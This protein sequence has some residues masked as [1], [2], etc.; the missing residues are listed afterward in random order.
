MN[1]STQNGF[2]IACLISILTSALHP[3]PKDVSFR[4]YTA[5]DGLVG[6]HIS[7]LLQD[8]QG[9]LWVGTANG[10]YR[11]DG[12]AFKA[13]KRDPSD[14]TSL[15]DNFIRALYEDSSAGGMLWVG[16]SNGL[17]ALDHRTEKLVHYRNEQKG[18]DASAVNF[19]RTL[20][21]DAQSSIWV[22]T[23]GGGLFKFDKSTRQFARFE[24]TLKNAKKPISPEVSAIMAGSDESIWIGTYKH[25][26]LRYDPASGI[27][28]QLVHDPQDPQSVEANTILTLYKDRN[29]TIW[30]GTHKGGLA[31]I[32][33]GKLRRE[34]IRV[35]QPDLPTFNKINSIAE[36]AD[37]V[38][39]LGTSGAG[40]I[41]YDPQ[42]GGYEI[43][44]SDP[45][46]PQKLSD[47]W[48]LCQYVD[49]A[50]NLWIGTSHGL[51]K[52]QS[53]KKKITHIKNIQDEPLSLVHNCVNAIWEDRTGKLWIGTDGGLSV[54]D[55]ESNFIA[56]Y[57]N[58]PNDARSLS[59]NFIQAIG[60]DKNGDIWIGTFGGGLNKFNRQ[61]QTF[62]RFRKDSSGA[63]HLSQNFVTSIYEDRR[64]DLWIGTLG[65]LNKFD[66]SRNGFIRYLSDTKNPKA[67]NHNGITCMF[68]DHAS[69][70][71][72]GTY[73]GGLNLMNRDSDEFIH[74][75]NDRSNPNSLS[76]DIVNCLY[77][78]KNGLLWIGTNSGLDR[79]DPATEQFSHYWE[80]DGLPNNV[81]LGILGDDG[82]NLWISTFNGLSKFDDGLPAGKKFLNFDSRKD[83]L[84]ANEFNTGAFHRNKRGELFFGGPNGLNRFYPQ[85]LKAKLL[86][87][88]IVIT[89]LNKFNKPLAL[90]TSIAAT[91]ELKFSHDDIFFSFDFAVLDFTLPER[92][93][94]AYRM[95][96]FNSDW[97]YCGNQHQATFT[98]LDAGA[99][100]FKVK[101][102]NSDGVW[103]EEGASLRI[104]IAPP[105][106][107]TWWF[108]FLVAMAFIGVL[109]SIYQYRV[110][111][112]LA[113][114]RLR[115]RIASDLH[116]DI[117]ATL[118]RISL[119]SELIQNG[120]DP[121]EVKSSLQK[122]GAMSRDLVTTMSDIVW[123]IDAR[124][125]T[126]GDLI[127][128]M[129][130]FASSVLSV[131]PVNVSFEVSGLDEHKRLP[132]PLRQNIYLI[133]KEA[134]NNIAKHAKAT[135]AEIYLK[136]SEGRF[137]MM[138]RDDG[139][140]F[141][142]NELDP[143]SAPLHQKAKADSAPHL[144]FTEAER[145]RG[146][147]TGHG[148]RNMKMR[149]ER[150][151]GN[152]EFKMDNGVSITL[153]GRAI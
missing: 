68:E 28:H 11:F 10:L 46:H 73:G 100:V 113:V 109:A 133:F 119:H 104:T 58:D 34:A 122:I 33:N 56:N 151:G 87:P 75:K 118:T 96:G 30:V 3:Q 13:F 41:A 142:E 146:K 112:L 25:G 124:N 80:K 65:G 71:W 144:E 116:D 51:N 48:I 5:E 82:G 88:A 81:V 67:L 103:N 115:V 98:N 66:R 135:K 130:D 117:G 4:R 60:E 106:W 20:W 136:N 38:L 36:D 105:Y 143:A 93:E 114:E 57:T 110:S 62:T 123:S 69:R 129:R 91:T 35:A 137:L 89:A 52:L 148:L 77:E 55:D 26:L 7:C 131:K 64:G 107:E 141:V 24:V 111:H 79:F 32:R 22:G 97:I 31:S 44:K 95:E 19:I 86:K 59:Q 72:I 127:D 102:A 21:E 14:T 17:N 8:H 152:L 37:G 15:S 139:A 49:R 27:F 2:L 125:D 16:T 9:F 63:G 43:F 54:F 40:L 147:L 149:A 101:G 121:K 83:G 90:E 78:D 18:L 53:P 74:Y 76:D 70:F 145:G 1:F 47:D 92:N 84:Q 42:T 85:D 132:V 45:Q 23:H 6:S 138:I 99:Y 29:E 134:I 39:W 12:Y 153:V 120:A 108:R 94:Y 140:G 126:V 150:I 128:R 50:G 61:N